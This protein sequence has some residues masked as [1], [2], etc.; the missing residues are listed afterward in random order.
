MKSIERQIHFL[1][2]DEE[3][4]WKRKSRADWLKEGDKNTKFFHFQA[5]S[6]R[7]KNKI[8]GIENAQGE[9]TKENE[10]IEKELCGYF[11][12]LFATSSPTQAQMEEV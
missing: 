10:N 5:S 7:R 3:I 12:K 6:R 11:V 8:W 1:L 4:F 9:W 2:L